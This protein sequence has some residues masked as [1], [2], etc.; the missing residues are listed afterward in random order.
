MACNLYP[1]IC[2]AIQPSALQL[3][4]SNDGLAS[5]LQFVRDYGGPIGSFATLLSITF[6][7]QQWFWLREAK[8]FD[9]VTR[10]L[11]KDDITLAEAWGQIG[12]AI[13]EPGPAL[14][15]AI[16][17]HT[18]SSLVEVL[19]SGNWLTAI[20]STRASTKAD[21]D[22][23]RAIR[24]VRGRHNLGQVWLRNTCNQLATAHLAVGAIAAARAESKILS[25]DDHRK[26]L[27]VAALNSFREVLKLDGHGK[28]LYAKEFEGEQLRRLGEF[29]P[30][31]KAFETLESWCRAGQEQFGREP[32]ATAFWRQAE[33][34]S[35]RGNYTRANLRMI[36]ALAVA[37]QGST[38]DL[39]TTLR[40]AQMHDFH[41]DV[42]LKRGLA[43]VPGGRLQQ[44]HDSAVELYLDLIKRLASRRTFW[45]R[46]SQWTAKFGTADRL[47]E[48]HS[49]A[50]EALKRLNSA[51]APA[52][53]D[54]SRSGGST[55]PTPSGPK[56]LRR[57]RLRRRLWRSGRSTTK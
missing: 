16:P 4:F 44:S 50:D 37:P 36:D 6:A 47:D 5:V 13:G 12:R 43:S 32:L 19:R 21:R 35:D 31:M 33:V 55:S 3:L 23:E 25:D 22:L 27:R 2:D 49:L 38:D 54:R 46:L 30:A 57:R 14:E 52:P 7:M 11:E 48:M 28:N 8:L 56:S 9:H 29:D 34:H 51:E 18:D 40:L 42:R 10:L 41:F 26:S 20:Q 1:K 24:L 15:I 53:K 45:R 17:R 39:R